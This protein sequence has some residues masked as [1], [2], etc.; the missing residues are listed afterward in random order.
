M[1]PACASLMCC[2]R[3]LEEH[4]GIHQHPHGVEQAVEH[5]D[6]HDLRR[7][8]G[9][10]VEVLVPQEVVDDDDVA[11]LPRVVRAALGFGAEIA[12]AGALENVEPRLTGVPVH[13]LATAGPDLEHRH[14]DTRG[15][16]AVGTVQQE[17]GPGATRGGQQLQLVPVG[18]QPARPPGPLVA[19]Q[20]A[21]PP[22]IRVVPADLAGIGR[23]RRQFAD[24]RVARVLDDRHAHGLQQRF[25]GERQVTR[26]HVAVVT[27][28]V[29]RPRRQVK[30][31]AWAPVDPLA[32]DLGPAVSG[33]HQHHGVPRM[34]VD[35]RGDAGV[36]LVR[37]GV[38][39]AGRAVAVGA[40]VHTD[41]G[42]PLGLDHL[43]VL[44]G[45]HGL[46]VAAPLLDEVG[47]SLLLHV[48]V[49][50]LGRGVRGHVCLSALT[51]LPSRLS[52]R[53]SVATSGH[54]RRS[55]SC[56]CRSTSARC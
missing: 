47:P 24:R 6:P 30:R 34:P 43:Y 20:P 13:R 54:P 26:G 33:H 4:H 29:P 8:L 11:L 15:L 16:V 5:V 46:L 23:T 12:V 27:R 48:V 45:D 19:R 3:L 49:R 38:H 35:G 39:R 17:R 41:A 55:R 52:F 31:I 51:Q 25:A 9:I 18:V 50:D 32:V 42:P 7:L 21:D 36:D 1:S 10:V 44:E 53:R 14:R 2:G 28:P 40:D 37:Q 22:C 56:T